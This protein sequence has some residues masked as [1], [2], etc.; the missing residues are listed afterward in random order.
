[1]LRA[2]SRTIERVVRGELC[3]GCGLCAS[4]SGAGMEA[5]PPGY[6][7]PGTA[8]QVDAGKEKLLAETCPGSLVAPWHEAPRVHPYWG[9]SHQV[10]TGYSTDAAVRHQASSGAG[11]T[12]L[13]LHALEAGLVD[14]VLQVGADPERPTRNV[15]MLSR[16]RQEV[17]AASGSRYAASSPLEQIETILKSGERVAFVGKPCDCSALRQLGRFDARVGERIPIILSFYCAGI[18]S[19]RGARAII[20]E[21]GLP[22]EE[23]ADFRYRGFGWPG[24]ATATTREGRSATMNYEESWGGHLSKEVQ[25]RCKICPDAVGGVADVACADAWYGGES[26][27]PQFEEQSGRSLIMVRTE[28]GKALVEA[29]VRAGALAVEPLEAGEIDLMQPAQARRKRL[30]KYRM[31]ALTATFQPK[32]RMAGLMVDQAA[33]R[34]GGKEALQNFVGTVRRILGGRR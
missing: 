21:M 26:G 27:Y 16:T 13:L 29:A 6:N 5:L 9:P 2:G 14:A 3:S 33:R 32:P 24:L 15:A 23:L 8:P 30:V 12:A 25:F 11:I 34:S 18:P 31:L 10:L 7:R 17:I 20:R 4:L 19:E 1:M 28:T 22:E